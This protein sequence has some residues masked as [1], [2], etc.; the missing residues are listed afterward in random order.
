MDAYHAFLLGN[1]QSSSESRLCVAGF[2]EENTEV[3]SCQSASYLFSQ[4]IVN[5]SGC[6]K[7]TKKKGTFSVGVFVNVFDET[8]NL[9]IHELN[10][11]LPSTSQFV[12]VLLFSTIRKIKKNKN[13]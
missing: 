3:D 5:K 4:I 6:N 10:S 1:I 9:R 8:S 2:A 11:S 7:S 12:S 13:K